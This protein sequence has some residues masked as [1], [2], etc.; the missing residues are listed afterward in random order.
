MAEDTDDSVSFVETWLSE[1]RE[2]DELDARMLDLVDE[3]RDGNELE[4]TAL[5]SAL[6][7]HA[8][9]QTPENDGSTR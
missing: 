3:H 8:D 4:E 9:T 7:E 6:V 2:D 1:N 5:L